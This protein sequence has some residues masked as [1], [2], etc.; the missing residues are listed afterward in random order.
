MIYNLYFSIIFLNQFDCSKS[1]YSIISY[2][3]VLW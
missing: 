3:L 1:R 2:V